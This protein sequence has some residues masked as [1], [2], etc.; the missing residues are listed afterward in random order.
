MAVDVQSFSLK[1]CFEA[2]ITRFVESK[3]VKVA[4]SSLVHADEEDNPLFLL[5]GVTNTY[6]P[7]TR[8]EIAFEIVTPKSNLL[9][10][11][12]TFKY[13]LATIQCDI[14]TVWFWYQNMKEKR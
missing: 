7:H 2:W 4:Q 3:A 13:H 8:Q 10:D 11:G 5:F 9:L 6:H 12:V 14:K 1:H